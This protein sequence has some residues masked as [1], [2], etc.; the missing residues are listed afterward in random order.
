[1]KVEPF[2]LLLTFLLAVLIG[3]AGHILGLPAIASLLLAVSGAVIMS[4]LATLR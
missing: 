2:R 4:R 3:S 1:M